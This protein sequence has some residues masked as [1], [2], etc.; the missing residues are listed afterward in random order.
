MTVSANVDHA[1]GGVLAAV[2]EDVLDVL[3]QLRRDV[4]VDLELAGVDDAHVHAG[5]DGV[6]QEGG[7]DGL[8]H[9]VVAAEGEREVGDAAG[10]VR[11]RGSA[12]LIRRAASMKFLA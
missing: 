1:L 11:A 5:L 8:A 2:E 3:E 10:D 4:L 7:V 6:V 9:G 12:R